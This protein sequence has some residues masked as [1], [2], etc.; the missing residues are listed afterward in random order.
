MFCGNLLAVVVFADL[1]DVD[2]AEFDSLANGGAGLLGNEGLGAVDAEGLVTVVHNR[3]V[4]VVEAES[5]RL[6]V[7]VLVEV[8]LIGLG[9]AKIEV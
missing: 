1:S 4:V 5:L 8:V 6:V 3:V 2:I 7:A 9:V